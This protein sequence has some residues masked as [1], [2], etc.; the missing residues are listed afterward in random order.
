MK[1][2]ALIVGAGIGGLAAGIAL[3][4]A[5]W[6]IRIFERAA[7]PRELGFGLALAP[8]AMAALDD[9]GLADVVSS[10]GFVPRRGEFRRPD[11]T[12]LK[13][14]A[15]PDHAVGEPLLMALRPALHGVLLEAATQDVMTLNAYAVGFEFHQDVLSLRFA[16]GATAEGDLLIGADGIDS[17]IRR[18]LHPDE[19]P[20]RPCGIV[21]IRGATH[22]AIH[23]LNGNDA[24]GYIGRGIESM[25]IRASDT[26]IY[27]FVSLN[28]SLIPPG[29]R[30]PAAALALLS[31][32][33]D[34]TFRAITSAASDL[35]LDTLADRDPLSS[36]GRGAATLLGDAAHPM[37]PQTGQ[38][39]AQALIDAVTLG[40]ALKGNASVE[41]GL[42]DYEAERMKTTAGWVHRGRRTARLMGT[43]NA[44]V[45]L[46][47]ELILRA[48][49][50]KPLM[51][52]YLGT[53]NAVS[54][55]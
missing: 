43:T 48:I 45:C 14:L 8:N 24:I 7:S 40:R 46:T 5:G 34:D 4:R 12:V 29:M 25:F 30:A 37:L 13:R 16:N 41:S 28:A 31:P 33:F 2:T 11:G 3:R 20:A 23:H 15:L 22:G 38:G 53:R 26:G 39:A 50:V 51:W 44:A 21:A 52:F 6:N 17:A 10:R 18:A 19:P 9:L 36:W 54:T 32:A 42:R 1:R 35:R 55:D 27:W 47:R 49:P